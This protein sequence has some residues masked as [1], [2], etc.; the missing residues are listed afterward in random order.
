MHL[1]PAPKKEGEGRKFKQPKSTKTGKGR[2]NKKLM[3]DEEFES[4]YSNIKAKQTN[5]QH[6]VLYE[7]PKKIRSKSTNYNDY[8]ND[9]NF[10]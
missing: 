5:N 4:I 7:Q 10:D 2:V 6:R 3:D 1:K 8:S 9:N